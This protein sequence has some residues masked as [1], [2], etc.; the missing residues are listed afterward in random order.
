MANH[1]RQFLHLF[2]KRYCDL[3]EVFFRNRDRELTTAEVF[4]SFDQDT[5]RE[6]LRLN[7]LLEEDSG[8]RLDE[9]VEE[10]LEQMLEAGDAAPVEWL[11]TD[12]KEFDRWEGLYHQTNDHSHQNRCTAKL[13]RILKQLRNRLLR[14][15]N[16]LQRAADYDYRTESNYEVKEAK[17]QWRLEETEAL[18][19]VLG[20]VDMRMKQATVF[21]IN[22]DTALLQARSLMI[23]AIL[24]VGQKG[25]EK[26]GR[27]KFP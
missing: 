25:R 15:N 10:F 14:Q 21:Q 2:Q 7:V 8:F 22:R 27:S 4:E 20:E 5:V 18:R 17:L 3:V 24:S 6:L 11:E 1:S 19:T 12:L 9:R 23:E 13:V 16:E 26:R